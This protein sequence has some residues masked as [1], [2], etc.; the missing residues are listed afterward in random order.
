MSKTV[1]D[2][3]MLVKTKLIEDVKKQVLL[4][5]KYPPGAGEATRRA[6]DEGRTPG[7]DGK[8]AGSGKYPTGKEAVAATEKALGRTLDRYEQT[9]IEN[10]A[11][12]DAD[13][14]GTYSARPP[15]GTVPKPAETFGPDTKQHE[16]ETF[17]HPHNQE[18][19]MYSEHGTHEFGVNDVPTVAETAKLIVSTMKAV[20]QTAR[21]SIGGNSMEM[22]FAKP[23]TTE[24]V[25]SIAKRFN[26]HP[27]DKYQKSYNEDHTYTDG[28]FSVGKNG[29]T[30]HLWYD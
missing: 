25:K 3:L 28:T 21:V 19:P 24:H 16:V 11:E 4:E 23:L 8:G 12:R 22:K 2:E 14:G 5:A 18:D 30:V 26:F 10:Q 20:G 9:G 29:K 15:V 1:H 7:S 6:I 17:L 27:G 13:A